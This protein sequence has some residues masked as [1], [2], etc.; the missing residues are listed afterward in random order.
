VPRRDVINRE[1]S[2]L[3]FNDRVLQEASDPSVPLVERLKF[4]GIFSSNLEE[5]FRV[6][7]ATLQRMVDAG[8]DSNKMIYGGSPR[9][10]LKQI[11][12]LVV[13]QRG[14][15]DRV[16]AEVR[17]AL[18]KEN[19]LLIDE[20]HILP[21][22][23]EF[24]QRYFDESVR[25]S[26]VP[27]ILD[28][29][30][31]FP[32][33]KN[34]VIYLAVRL[35]SKQNGA[36]PRH[37][38]IEVATDRLPRF[39]VLPNVGDKR[40][41]IMLDDVIRF[42]LKD[43][44]SIF[45]IDSADAYTIKLTRDAEIEIDD[46]VTMSLM[47][48]LSRSL[49]KRKEGL[50][51]RF[52]YDRE[53]PK[54]LLDFIMKRA[55]LRK[56]DNVIAGGRYHNA[57]DFVSFP[58]VIGPRIEY[59]PQPPLHHPA[60]TKTTSVLSV[61]RKQDVLLHLPYQS[62]HHV[63][64]MLREA[65]IDPRV[66]SISM[67]LYRVASDSHIVNSLINA[68]RNGKKVTVLFELQA[69][70]DEEANI[71]WTRALEDEGARLIGGVP[72]LKVHAKVA[73]ITRKEE[74]KLVDYALV[75]TG[76]FNEGTARVYA[77]HILM[78]SNERV[79][80]ELRKLFD[81][82][83]TNY[84]THQYHD[85]MVSPFDMRKMLQKLIRREI[86]NAHAGKTA[87]IDVKLNSL[88]DLELINLLYDA[89]RAGVKIRLIVRGICSLIPGLAGASENIE[90]VSIIDRYLEH[91]RIFFFA[92]GGNERCYLSSG[93]WM[94]RNLDFRVEVAVPVYDDAVRAELRYY[95]NVQ[96]RDTAK[97]RVINEAQDNQYRRG[98]RN[99]RAQVD[100]YRWL[101]RAARHRVADA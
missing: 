42:G 99:H 7:V 25:P 40:Y 44:F 18:E 93:D 28:T 86:K 12:E 46:D 58:N 31:E 83:E 21:E 59:E 60:L 80:A 82:L 81:F 4:I 74:G 73:L 91:S 76:N 11:H 15:F 94:T 6:R 66:K 53:L 57:R 78:T 49:K 20:R 34:G 47:D 90:V 5:F 16:F 54:D 84:R 9:R 98:P 26:L 92:N 2:W 43:V 36:K 71:R 23:H 24:V 87:Y 1:I 69:R 33:L 52:V 8:I 85:I 68:V 61:V 41:V 97:A 37:A 13:D 30:P 95:F 89:S 88:V 72:G 63:S 3:S 17:A 62:F 38:L 96:L 50:P 14:R 79:T 27:V 32:Y 65:A 45:E 35:E 22:H 64:D 77:D 100:I 67:T 39:L 29:L 70:F 55:N 48:K 51:V 101:S 75:G 19:V 10:V 56:L